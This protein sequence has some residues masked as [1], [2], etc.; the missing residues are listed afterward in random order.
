MRLKVTNNTFGIA[1]HQAIQQLI[2]IALGDVVFE[3]L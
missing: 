2:N 1:I 3:I